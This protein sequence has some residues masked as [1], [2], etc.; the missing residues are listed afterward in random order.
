MAADDDQ[1]YIPLQ[2]PTGQKQAA[3]VAAPKPVVAAPKPVDPNDQG[4]VPLHQPA[5]QTGGDSGAAQPSQPGDWSTVAWNEAMMGG[6]PGLRAQA[7]AARKR[8]DPLTAASADA[9]GGFAADDGAQLRSVGGA[10]TRGWP[11]RRDQE[12]QFAARLG[13]ELGRLEAD[14][15]GHSR[16]RRW[17]GSSATAQVRRSQSQS[18]SNLAQA[19]SARRLLISSRHGSQVRS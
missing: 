2:G 13:A 12:L 3:P 8:L 9:A 18:C 7:E 11:A 15:Q 10:R 1:G 6:S 19:A 14:R 17:R 5:D 4:Y 16:W